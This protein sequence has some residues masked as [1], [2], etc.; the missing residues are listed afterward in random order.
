VV[1]GC[2]VRLD[3]AGRLTGALARRLSAGERAFRARAA[4]DAIVVVSGGRR[5]TL[6]VE[7][8][9]MALE[10]ERLG[11]DPRAIVRERCSLSTRDNATFS[12]ALLAR[13]GIR[14]AG[15]VTCPWHMPRALSLFARAGVEATPI[16]AEDGP[17]PAGPARFWRWGREWVLMLLGV[18]AAVACAPTR[19]APAS[20]AVD[21]GNPPAPAPAAEVL[22]AIARAEDLRRVEALPAGVQASHDVAVRRAAARALAR[23]LDPAEDPQLLRALEDDDDQVVEW[24]GYGLGESCAGREEVHVRALVS[25]L[26]SLRGGEDTRAALLRALG[27]CGGDPAETT[28]RAW[29]ARGGPGAPEAAALALGDIAGRK[30]TLATATVT[31]LLDAVQ[32]DPPLDAALYALGRAEGGGDDAPRRAAAARAA[33]GRPGTARIFAVR[34]LARA[35]DPDQAV[36]ELARVVGSS[37]FSPAERVEAARELARLGRAAHAALGDL[38]AT[39]VPDRAD[40]LAGPGFAVLQAVLEGTPETP[41]EGALPALWSIARLEPAAGATPGLARRV[42]LVRCAAARRLARGAWGSDVMTRCDL[43]DGEIGERA[44]LASLERH[45]FDGKE[46]RAAWL[47]LARSAR[48][49]VREAALEAIARHPELGEVARAALGEALAAKE[50]GVVAAAAHVVEAHPERVMALAESERRAALDPAAPPPTATPARELDPAVAQAL[51]AALARPWSEDLVETRLA[52]VGAGLAVALPEAIASA[53]S[54]CADRNAT[55]RGRAARAL[56]VAGQSGAVCPPPPDPGSA[57]PELGHLAARAATVILD[58]DAGSLSLRLDPALAPVAVTRVLALARSGFYAGVVVH[59]VVPGFVV[60]FGDPGG[61]GYGGAGSLLRSET[62][63][64][65][66]APFDVGV[67]LDGRD[68]GSSQLFV[69]LARHPR[70]DGQY[71]WLGHAQGPWDAV[72]EGDVVRSVRVAE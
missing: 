37:K 60:Q 32:A 27:R 7:A 61:D 6:D 42:S 15:V 16:P 51:R 2:R 29:L 64:V 20:A 22:A 11:V 38:L 24:A 54:A 3:E 41:A 43:G 9:R 49:R 56:A 44:R 45:P 23:I 50:P 69:A 13:R 17:R 58:T 57:A 30:G 65:S 26:A 55:V 59:R 36:P 21:A 66:F 18:V 53:R 39:L 12:A 71:A 33:L 35:G 70:L 68:T 67:A 1:L 4:P 46:R 34:A 52:L 63:P 31:A 62:S 40:E 14:R 8:D 47:Q 5:W 19:A 28:L 10:I 48:V 25:R 72:V